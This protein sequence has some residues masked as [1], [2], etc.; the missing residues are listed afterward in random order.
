MSELCGM[1]F[2]SPAI[3]PAYLVWHG[4][5]FEHGRRLEIHQPKGIWLA[6]ARRLM[7]CEECY[8]RA[9]GHEDA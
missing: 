5:G 4:L 7:I 3:Y 6:T 8:T 1:C 9:G 2:G